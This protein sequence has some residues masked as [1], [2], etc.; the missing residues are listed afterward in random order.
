MC[1]NTYK[2]LNDGS[3]GAWIDT[4]YGRNSTAKPAAGDTVQI[5]TKSS[6][7]HTRVVK[8]IVKNYASGCVVS[9]VADEAIAAKAAA[10]YAAKAKTAAP[11]M[12]AVNA[13]CGLCGS[14]CYGDCTAN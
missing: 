5:R 13:L 14:Y 4:G 6:E 9:L 2:K 10:S 12:V 3:Y 1:K 11:R 8:G 7:T